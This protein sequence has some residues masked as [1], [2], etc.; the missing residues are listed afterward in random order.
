[1]KLRGLLTTLLSLVAISWIAA[2]TPVNNAPNNIYF[3][4]GE[5]VG[6]TTKQQFLSITSESE[7]HVVV[8][9]LTPEGV[10]DWCHL[11]KTSGN[12][13]ANILMYFGENTLTEERSLTITVHFPNEVQSLL[14]TQRF[15]NPEQPGEEDLSGWL[16]L[17]TFEADGERYF[18]S[19]HMLPSTNNRQRSFSVFYDA[20]NFLPLWV[21]Y[22]LCRGNM[23]GSGNR[24]ND[25]GIL[26]P[27]IPT[28]KQLYMKN[29]YNGSYDRGHMLPSASRLGSTEDNRQTFYP[30]NMTPQLAGLNQQKWAVIEGYVRDWAEGCDTLYVV[31]GAVLKTVG[32][33]E[34]ISYTYCK[35]DSSKDVAIPNYYYKALLQYRNIN[36][37]KSYQALG[38][39]VPHKP[40]NGAP[41][42]E[43]VMTID[44][45]EEITGLD[46]F[47][48]LEESIQ[49][50]V[51]STI[52]YLF[53]GGIE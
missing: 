13:N 14:F 33:N 11:N 37:A 53:W 23:Y 46:F 28:E 30:T 41:T 50:S 8:E 21:A 16:E 2:C 52:D 4:I 51:E 43:D 44:E 48:N 49:S 42:K 15:H 31:T 27:N 35:S 20:D 36:G 45:L 24:V 1:M 39:W 3:S 18:H 6:Y 40:A 22:P 34:T 12:G 17:P 38:L 9:Y 10:S 26:D 32:G 29:S 19:K 7:W 25:W 47:P 5:T